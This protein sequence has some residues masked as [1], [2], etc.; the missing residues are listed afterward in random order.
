M[1]SALQG[2]SEGTTGTAIAGNVNTKVLAEISTNFVRDIVHLSDHLCP[3]E[4]N[5]A[6]ARSDAVDMAG[7]PDT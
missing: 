5:P 6:M 4:K 1:R 2:G 3:N 7:R